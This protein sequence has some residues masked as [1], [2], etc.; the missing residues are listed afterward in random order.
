MAVVFTPLSMIKGDTKYIGVKLTGL[1]ETLTS[2]TFSVKNS[3]E[4][5]ESLFEKTLG[6][7]IEQDSENPELCQ[8]RIDQDD[9]ADLPDLDLPAVTYFY[10][11]SIEANGDKFS[12]LVGTLEVVKG[13]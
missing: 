3:L 13:A 8:V 12:P 9:T 1:T 4:D 7:G 10:R 5:A 2:A 11:L 6:D